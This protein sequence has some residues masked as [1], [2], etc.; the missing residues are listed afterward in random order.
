MAGDA[1]V[2]RL[3]QLGID[4]STMCL[5]H[6]R[7][8]AGLTL[9]IQNGVVSL[10]QSVFHH[11]VFELFLHGFDIVVVLVVAW[12]K[13]R[14]VVLDNIDVPVISILPRHNLYLLLSLEPLATA[15]EG[16]QIL[17]L[18]NG[19]LK[20]PLL[21]VNL[22]LELLALVVVNVAELRADAV[23]LARLN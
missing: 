10:L 14:L 8:K 11:D 12:T 4:A 16:H 9:A 5:L 22:L 7:A 3:L 18:S 17:L 21:Y 15:V 13:I 19:V 6:S 23:L 2:R 20:L 1:F